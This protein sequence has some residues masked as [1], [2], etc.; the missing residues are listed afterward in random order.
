MILIIFLIGCAPS[1][2]QIDATQIQAL[3]QKDSTIQQDSFAYPIKCIMTGYPGWKHP[4]PFER[5]GT[6]KFS[7]QDQP[8]YTIEIDFEVPQDKIRFIENPT[9]IKNTRIIESAIVEETKNSDLGWKCSYDAQAKITLFGKSFWIQTGT[10]DHNRYQDDDRGWQKQGF[11]PA[12]GDKLA[13][14]MIRY[15][16]NKL[17]IYS[18]SNQP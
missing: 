13:I 3:P 8:L 12:V 18:I 17:I 10:N 1:Q 14:D 4:E 2:T 9:E 11:Q 5:F 7:K 16:P 15:E 6:F